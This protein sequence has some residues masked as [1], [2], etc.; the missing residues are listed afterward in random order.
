MSYRDK[1]Y[2][3]CLVSV[4]EPGIGIIQ[5]NRPKAF[6]AVNELLLDESL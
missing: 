1:Q 5:L 6:N 4:E 2:E 3:T